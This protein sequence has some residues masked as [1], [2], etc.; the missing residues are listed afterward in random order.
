VFFRLAM[1]TCM[2]SAF[3]RPAMR[4][5]TGPLANPAGPPDPLSFP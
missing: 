4:L 2:P 3:P 1:S 5:P